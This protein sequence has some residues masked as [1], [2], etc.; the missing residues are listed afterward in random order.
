[1]MLDMSTIDRVTVLLENSGDLGSIHF[2]LI[3]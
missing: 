1:M 2:S 3:D